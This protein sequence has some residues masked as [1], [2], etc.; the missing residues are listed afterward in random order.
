MKFFIDTANLDEISEGLELGLVDG[1]TTNPSLAAKEELSFDELAPK[2]CEM[3]GDRPVSL[4]V[5]SLEAR[6]MIDEARE[7]VKIADNVVIKLPLTPDGLKACAALSADG[8][9]VNQTLI[10]NPLQALLAAKAGATYV[11]PFVGR[12]DDLGVAGMASIEQIV[13]IFNNYGY[14]TEVLVAS[15]RSPMHILEAAIYGADVSTIPFKV[16]KGLAGHPLTDIG[17]EK[18]LAD[19]ES[20]KG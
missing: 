10:F 4:E 12:V 5:V 14:E 20:R 3:V 7:L 17:L 13:T 1:V 15:V 6:G 16:L 11:S 19:W 18:F 8:I 2:I 9:K